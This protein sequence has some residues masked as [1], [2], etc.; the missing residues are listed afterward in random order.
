MKSL[1]AVLLVLC[2]MLL[3]CGGCADTPV[4]SGHERAQIIGRNWGYEY[5]EMQDDID[6]FLL[7]R[8][9]TRLSIWHVR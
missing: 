7:L 9:S 3:T 6:H 8:P 2:G 5:R 1:A 4:Y